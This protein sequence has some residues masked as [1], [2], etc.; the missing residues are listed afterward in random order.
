[1]SIASMGPENCSCVQAHVS[2][3]S[4]VYSNLVKEDIL[5]IM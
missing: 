2:S 4:F 3:V 1:M 5:M